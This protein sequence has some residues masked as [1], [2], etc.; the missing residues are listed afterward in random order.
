M[1]C[2]GCGKRNTTNRGTA[3]PAEYDLAGGVDI[4]SLNNRQITARL[5]VFKRK[6]C[7]DCKDRYVCDYSNYL[8]CLGIHKK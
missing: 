1:A 5:E 7:S 8:N 2:G 3:N 6:F 4:K